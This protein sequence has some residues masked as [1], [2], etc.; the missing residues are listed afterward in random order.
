MCDS[1]VVIRFVVFDLDGTLVD[2]RRDL[3]NAVNAMLAE[4]ARPALPEAEITAM[5]GEGAALLVTRALA[6]SGL[7]PATPGAL[8]RFLELYDRRLLEHT[9]P[10]EGM[11]ATLAQLASRLPLAVLT[12]K[13]SAATERVLAGLDLRQYFRSVVGGDTTLGRKPNPVAMRQMID[14]AGAA[15]GTTL[16]VGDSAIDLETSRRAG[17]RICLA[18]Y[19]FG[20]RFDARA[21]RGDELFIDAPPD[22]VA[23][24]EVLAQPETI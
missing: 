17:T 1:H 23:L 21:F 3:A 5:V 10:Y 7:D 22:L 20:F 9:R 4:L 18:R 11:P 12:N 13:P 24:I 14:A 8:G 16:L 15:P 19:G 6:A 2:S